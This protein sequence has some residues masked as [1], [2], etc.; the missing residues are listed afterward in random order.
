MRQSVRELQTSTTVW[1]APQQVSIARIEHAAGRSIGVLQYFALPQADNSPTLLSGQRGSASV[2]RTRRG[3]FRLPHRRVRADRIPFRAVSRTSMPE[4]AVNKHCYPTTRQNQ[5]RAAALGKSPVQ[6]KA[7][8]Q[9]MQSFPQQDLGLRVLRPATAKLPAA[10]SLYPA[11]LTHGSH[12]ARCTTTTF[13][14]LRSYKTLRAQLARRGFLFLNT[15]LKGRTRRRSLLLE[16]IV[17]IADALE[18]DAE[19][20]ITGLAAPADRPL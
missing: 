9:P 2:P 3:E 20:L 8:T 4:V 7:C 12:S 11:D 15:A 5:I 19:E 14:T 1:S 16:M 10:S 6:A 13:G 18:I 17:K